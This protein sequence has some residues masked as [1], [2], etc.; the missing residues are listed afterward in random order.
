VAFFL[1]QLGK[2]PFYQNQPLKLEDK[3]GGDW[4]EWPEDWRVRELPEAFWKSSGV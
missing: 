2:K 4:A 3:H 1:K